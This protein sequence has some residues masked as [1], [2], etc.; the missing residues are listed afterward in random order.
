MRVG[1]AATAHSWIAA[2]W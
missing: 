2:R 1:A